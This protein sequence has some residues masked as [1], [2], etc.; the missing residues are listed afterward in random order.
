MEYRV[1]TLAAAAGVRVDTVRFYQS[2]G[3]LPK[4]GRRGRLAIYDADHLQRLRRIRSLLEQGF[5]LAQIGRVMQAG[6]P[7]GSTDPVLAALAEEVGA[8][9]TYTRAELAAEVGI[10][11]SLIQAVEAAGLGE[12]LEIGGEPRFVEADLEMAKA[13]LAVL[14]AGFPL[15]ALLGL[16]T[17]HANHVREVADAA[18]DLFD[19]HIRK[20]AAG[21][22]VIAQ[23]FRSLLPQITRLVALHFQRTLVN[24]ALERLSTSEGE[25]KVN[26]ERALEATRASRLEVEWR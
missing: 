10:P 14:G 17:R 25:D 5:S 6:E 21:G 20:D 2:R 24:R 13:A 11:E 15:D 7:G 8:A 22:E 26:L 3:L 12:P 4:P 18:I 16:S 1:E 9:R 19:D 23:A